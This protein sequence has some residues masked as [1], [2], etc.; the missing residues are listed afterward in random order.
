MNE[1]DEDEED[2]PV[3]FYL[4]ES[5]GY[6]QPTLSFLAALHTII[7]FICIIGYNCLKIPL[8]IFKREKELARKLEFDGLY[9]TEQPE[10]DDI[11]GQW[12]R[13]VLNTPSFPNNYWDKFVKRKV[14][15]KY[16]DIYGRERIAELLGVDLASLDVS[17]QHEKKQEEPDN[18]V[19]AWV[20]S[21]DIKYQIWKF[22]VVFTDGTFLYLC[23]YLIMSLLGHYNNFFFACHLL[24]IAMGVKTLRTI[25]SSV[26]H[27]GKQ[28]SAEKDLNMVVYLYTVVA[29]NFF[30]KFYNKSEDEDEPDMKCDDMMTCYLFH[31]YVGVRAGGGIGDEIEDPAG[32]EYELYRV[33]FDITFFFFVIVILLAI[34]Q[35]LIIDAFGELRDQ[36]EQVKEDM[37]TKCF[38]CGIGS[39]YFD[40]TPHGFE[41][42]TFDE[43]NLANYMFFLMYLINKDETEHTGQNIPAEWGLGQSIKTH[44]KPRAFHSSCPQMFLSEPGYTDCYHERLWDPSWDAQDVCQWLNVLKKVKKSVLSPL[45]PCKRHQVPPLRITLNDLVPNQIMDKD[46]PTPSVSNTEAPSS[47][48][49]TCGSPREK[50]DSASTVS[51]LLSILHEQEM[52]ETVH[53]TDG[54]GYLATFIGKN[55]RFVILRVH[56]HGLITIDLQ[57][58]EE[59]NITQLDNLLNALEKKLTLLLKGNIT[60]IKRLPALVRGA[61]VDRYWPTADG[62]LMEYD[63]DQVLY[64]EDSAYQ[65]IKILRSQQYGNILVL[66]GDVNLAESDLPYTE[67]IM[68]NGKEDY[69]GKEKVID[70]CKTHMRKTCGN[71]LDNLKGDCYQIL[72][73]DCVP[74]LKKY[75]QEGRTFDYIINDLTAVP[76]STEPE[77]DSTWEFLRLILDLSIK[78]LHP[79]GKYFTQGNS[80]NLTEALSSY[81]EQLGKLSCPVDFSKEVVC[82]P[83]YMELYPF[84]TFLSF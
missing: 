50:A 52:T 68:G 59:D 27:N 46:P 63:I 9:I 55:G 29:F 81:E 70:G 53:D 78:I 40:T 69:A 77:E 34:I 67:A 64:E 8:V 28:A 30:R 66:N 3:Y 60:R 74:V 72:V 17:Q 57:C 71:I 41:T 54:H 44:I 65:N 23:W 38:I 84:I 76:I 43:H 73:E 42:H 6:M 16:G 79:T 13:L 15:D 1:G 61:K 45:S 51:A 33:V 4:E 80:V 5:T 37:E 32:D 83:S 62:R 24:D 7:S 39:D 48:P 12:D 25:L 2:V 26:T 10:D 47:G 19:F 82:V 31:M 49:V 75:V 14:L 35:G 56:S 22:G 36:Q 18:S 11:K 20:T 21:I 58:Y